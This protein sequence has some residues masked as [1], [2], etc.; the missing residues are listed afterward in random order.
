MIAMVRIKTYLLQALGYMKFW[1]SNDGFWVDI[2]LDI[3]RSHGDELLSNASFII[4]RA[5]NFFFWALCFLNLDLEI[6][7]RCTGFSWRRQNSNQR[8]GESCSQTTNA[9]I[10]CLIARCW[11][12]SSLRK[13]RPSESEQLR[14][15]G[16][17]CVIYL[18]VWSES[19]LEKKTQK[20]LG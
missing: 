11:N 8:T 4:V 13:A 20:L 15:R 9:L 2:P 16:A 17:R 14:R 18:G 6:G 7:I 5:F 1:D 19:K 12:R 3:W 10:G